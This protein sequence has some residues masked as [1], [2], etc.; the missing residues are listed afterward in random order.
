MPHHWAPPSCKDA[1][2]HP[3]W[4]HLNAGTSPICHRTHQIPRVTC[5][6]VAPM[7]AGKSASAA[8]PT[9]RSECSWTV[10]L[11][12]A[13]IS[14]H[15]RPCCLNNKTHWLL[16]QEAKSQ[17][18]RC[19]QG[20]FFLKAPKGRICSRPLSLACRH[21]CSPVSSQY[22]PLGPSWCPSFLFLRIPDPHQWP[23]FNY[24]CKDCLHII[25]HKNMVFTLSCN[26]FS[27]VVFMNH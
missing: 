8:Y 3:L 15:H 5:R 10:I 12:R 13:I 14:K 23:H 27:T 20:W 26:I 6:G 7:S 25:F 2:C 24:L 19:L 1:T 22:L 4:A 9:T 18:G 16:A 11:V 17:I 21:L